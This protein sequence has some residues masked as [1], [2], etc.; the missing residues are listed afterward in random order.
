MDTNKNFLQE[1]LA[2]KV[3]V[4]KPHRQAQESYLKGE[5]KGFKNFYLYSSTMEIRTSDVP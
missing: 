5:T 3:S 4:W 2:K 1:N